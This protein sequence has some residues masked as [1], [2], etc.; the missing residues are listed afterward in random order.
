ALF[1]LVTKAPVRR[2][3]DLRSDC[4]ASITGRHK[5]RRANENQKGSSEGNGTFW[6]RVATTTTYCSAQHNSLSAVAPCNTRR[7]RRHRAWL[8]SNAGMGLAR[9]TRLFCHLKMPKLLHCQSIPSES[10]GVLKVVLFVKR[11]LR[12]DGL[13]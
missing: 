8:G 12:E 10:R 2:R 9:S 5:A 6:R 3:T 7:G 1:A 11:E 13:I 4:G